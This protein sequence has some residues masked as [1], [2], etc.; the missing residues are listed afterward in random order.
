MTHSSWCRN[1]RGLLLVLPLCL[2]ACASSSA[3]AGKAKVDTNPR[4]LTLELS[5]S[6]TD[7][8]YTAFQLQSDGSFLFAGGNAA[9]QGVVEPVGQLTSAEIEELIARAQH[10]GW[11]NAP[12][13]RWGDKPT[14]SEDR[15]TIRLPGAGSASLRVID[16]SVAGV[17]ELHDLL[18]GWQ[19]QRRYRLPVLQRNLPGEAP[20]P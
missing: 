5:R 6:T 17:D 1:L 13:A 20:T 2:S 9:R 4:N 18:F 16:G 12:S 19:A 11:F 3:T 7:R 8:R 10:H 14:R 15:L